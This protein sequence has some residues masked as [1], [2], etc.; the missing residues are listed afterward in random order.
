MAAQRNNTTPNLFIT[1]FDLFRF[2]TFVT[3]GVVRGV[4]TIST[5]AGL[6]SAVRHTSFAEFVEVMTYCTGASF[7]IRWDHG[8]G[9]FWVI[10]GKCRS[11]HRANVVLLTSR[12]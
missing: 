9:V 11:L 3:D 1:L 4:A 8:A 2:R 6:E 12:N 5:G 7:N 10:Y